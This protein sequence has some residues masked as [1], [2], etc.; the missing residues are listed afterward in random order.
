M[1]ALLEKAM[2]VPIK[3]SDGFRA[4]RERLTAMFELATQHDLDEVKRSISRMED[5]LHEIKSTSNDLL[6]KTG[7]EKGGKEPVAR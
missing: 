3:L 2:S 5:L 4:K 6:N 7:A 1:G